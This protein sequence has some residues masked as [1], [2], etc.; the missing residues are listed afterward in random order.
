MT[1]DHELALVR[2]GA[3]HWWSAGMRE[4]SWALLG[5]AAGRRL[6]VGCGPGLDLLKL[7]PNALG[8]GL[9]RTT[10]HAAIRP[11]VQAGANRLPFRAESFD[12]VLALD[13]L[14]QN[15]VD[16]E[17][18]LLE[19]RRVVRSEGRM[20]ARVP[21][22]PW[23]YG[24]HDRA[25]G[26]TRRYRKAELRALIE[27]AGFTIGRLTY[28]NGFLFPVAAV[29]RLGGRAGLVKDDLLPLAQPFGSLLMVVLSS[30]ARWL[31]EHDLPTRLSLVCLART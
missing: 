5:D 15:R 25:W 18:V 21:A 3:I 19:T 20:L 4:I 7:P 13:L 9:D 8:V 6:D 2:S 17:A 29:V 30:E 27:G 28:A 14:E 23:L 26:G 1:R 11:L 16:P 31:R 22:H 12:L 24:P 10:G